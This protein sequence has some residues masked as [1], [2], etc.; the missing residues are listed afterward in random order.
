MARGRDISSA[1]L[2]GRR[3]CLPFAASCL[4]PDNAVCRNLLSSD[5]GPYAIESLS[6]PGGLH[7]AIPSEDKQGRCPGKYVVLLERRPGWRCVGLNVYDKGACTWRDSDQ[8]C[9]Y[10]CGAEDLPGIGNWDMTCVTLA[11]AL[12]IRLHPRRSQLQGG[13][14]GSG[15]RQAKLSDVKLETGRKARPH[16]S[17]N[18]GHCVAPATRNYRDR[19][20]PGD[21]NRSS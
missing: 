8:P 20:V 14:R 2:V 6:V 18:S 13:K 3:L 10:I 11:D 12:S 1:A 9:E 7:F 4:F 15:R 19:G 17:S 21:P 16:A 5:C